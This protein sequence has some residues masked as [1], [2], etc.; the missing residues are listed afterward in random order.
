M[1]NDQKK[2]DALSFLELHTVG[3]LA[4]LSPE[5]T[6]HA[7]PVYY[8]SDSS[9]AIYFLTLSTTQK[10]VD[11]AHNRNAA[12]VIT[13]EHVSQ[14]LQIEGTVE[15]RTDIDIPDVVLTTLLRRIR[16]NPTEHAP[17][18]RLDLGKMV[19][20]KLT[21]TSVRWGDFTSGRSTNDVLV[22]IPLD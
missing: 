16:S 17:L 12:F 19:P 1:N 6:P 9:F 18:E 22:Q 15:N 13:D 10:A 14:M 20:Y 21:P 7:R 3:V 5:S 4:T 11:L 2:Q 8:A